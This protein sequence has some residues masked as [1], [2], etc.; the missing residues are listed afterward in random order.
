M[1]RNLCSTSII[2]MLLVIP[3]IYVS[4]LGS[5]IIGQ[6]GHDKLRDN[7]LSDYVT[8]VPIFINHD[9]NFTT[10]GWLGSG[11]GEDPYII[12]NLN[13]TTDDTCVNVT[14]TRAHFIIRN[15][16]FKS[17]TY[18]YGCSVCFN[19]V[20]Y[21]SV[22]DTSMSGMGYGVYIY[23]SFHCTLDN[24]SIN[25][26]GDSYF[27]YSFNITLANSEI[28]NC[29]GM[30]LYITCSSNC[31]FIG[32]TISNCYGG[33]KLSSSEYATVV[34]CEFVGN[35]I[36]V[37][38]STAPTFNHN[39]TGNTAN[40][41]ALG[42][43]YSESDKIINGS[44]YGSLIL[45]LCDNVTIRS[46]AF[47]DVDDGVQLVY[48][49][50]CIVEDIETYGVGWNSVYIYYSENTTIQNSHFYA[51]NQNTLVEARFSSGTKILYNQM[52]GSSHYATRV[53]N[54]P[55]S[56]IIG[57]GF[58]DNFGSIMCQYNDNS[59][60]EGNTIYGSEENAAYASSS[61]DLDILNNTFIGCY[62]GLY[63][64]DMGSS[65]I[66]NN[67]FSVS[68]IGISLRASA[69][70]IMLYGNKLGWNFY[71]G[72][73][74]GV[75]NTW[76]N[77]EDL[78][79]HWSD[80]T[81]PGVYNVS[82]PAN[83]TDRYPFTLID[84]TPPTIDHPDDVDYEEGTTGHSIIWS[85]YD[86]YPREWELVRNGTPID[87][88]TWKAL[89]IE[90]DVDG[91]TPGF[92]NFTIIIYDQSD[93]AIQDTVLVQVTSVATT[94]TTT[95]TSTTTATTGTSTTSTTSTDGNGGTSLTYLLAVGGGA[96]AMLL[97]LV[98][99]Y[100]KKRKARNLP[101]I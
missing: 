74:I 68:Y 39:I 35:S 94:T 43:F 13:I 63:F 72:Y 26:C 67:T 9:N 8:H 101:R 25:N 12:E 88:R 62:V 21:G 66:I 51:N 2:V 91:L 83:A 60:I 69:E 36:R 10:Q 22:V 38:G 82:G 42:F 93:N 53:E 59:I 54:S 96:V 32:N 79:N 24:L 49:A 7:V 34:D 16:V 86:L 18:H 78:G 20:S 56:Q 6:G 47:S 45:V 65:H 55:D 92:W 73:D 70:D 4:T 76:D 37:T 27:L 95:T 97:V 11:T 90:L 81:P 14:N 75:N 3:L 99:F 28:N 48:C 50:N 89:P 80:Y 1:R 33:L 77:G 100:N 41:R 87:S 52:V 57:N 5:P 30:A 85:P 31:T 98:L 58:V 15:C 19:N 44:Q 84:E 61:V 71:N 40:N 17:I 23:D 64:W 29:C 46:G